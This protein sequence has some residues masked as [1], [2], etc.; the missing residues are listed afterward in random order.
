MVEI[1]PEDAQGGNKFLTQSELGQELSTIRNKKILPGLVI[2]KL[3]YK[4]QNSQIQL[5]SNQLYELINKINNEIKKYNNPKTDQ[6]NMINI[7]RETP[8]PLSTASESS[9]EQNSMQ[10]LIETLEK[11]DKR[12]TILEENTNTSLPSIQ[13]SGNDQIEPLHEISNDT[14]HI[15]ILMKWLQYLVDK[16]GKSQLTEIL[17]YYVDIGWISDDVRLDMIDYAKGITDIIPKEGSKKSSYQLTT[18]DHI[19]SLL[20]IQKLKGQQLDE[21]F[22]SKIDREMQK[23]SRSIEQYQNK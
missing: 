17:T 19:Q 20:F 1:V 7:P 15:V 13:K 8:I 14:E 11:I 9:I 21:R 5:T 12:L 23:L 16:T 2:D 22:I 4:L 3:S 10:Q 6:S 18:K